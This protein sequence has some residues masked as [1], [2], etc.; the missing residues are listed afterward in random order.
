MSRETLNTRLLEM[1]QRTAHV[2]QRQVCETDDVAEKLTIVQIRT[3]DELNRRGQMT[4]ADLAKY[5]GITPASATSLAERLVVSG[6]LKRETDPDDR[7]KVRIVIDEDK[8]EVWKSME[9]KRLQRIS[10]FLQAL[11][12][13]E[14]EDFIRILESLLKQSL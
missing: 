10:M 1:F 14:K 11:S 7:R 13:K 3:L 4:M 12:D 5:L 8:R 6:W 2:I 9:Q